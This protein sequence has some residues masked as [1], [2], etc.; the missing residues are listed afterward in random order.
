MH[1]CTMQYL[2]G[3]TR[4][5]VAWALRRWCKGEIGNLV[6]SLVP[7]LSQGDLRAM[8]RGEGSGGGGNAGGANGR[9]VRGR[10]ARDSSGDAPSPSRLKRISS[11]ACIMSFEKGDHVIAR[12]KNGKWYDATVCK[13]Q[14]H[15]L[16]LITWKDRDARDRVKRAQHIRHCP[17]TLKKRLLSSSS[18][19]A[20][21]ALGEGRQIDFEEQVICKLVTWCGEPTTW[22]GK[23]EVVD[24]FKTSPTW[25]SWVR[26]GHTEVQ[27]VKL[28]NRLKVKH[29]ERPIQHFPTAVRTFKTIVGKT[30]NQGRGGGG[31]RRASE[32]EKKEDKK[33]ICGKR[34]RELQGNTIPNTVADTDA[35][36]NAQKRQ[37]RGS[38]MRAAPLPSPAGG[39]MHHQGH[40][41]KGRNKRAS[42]LTTRGR[43]KREKEKEDSKKLEE[44]ED[45]GKRITRGGDEQMQ[46][47]STTTSKVR[48]PTLR[49]WKHGKWQVHF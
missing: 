11:A 3:N 30:L 35:L 23:K 15:G 2:V 17:S 39:K 1:V 49:I 14:R 27:L 25:H 43:K 33:G 21:E 26:A 22:N 12:Y 19:S 6:S 5:K 18:Q 32:G 9:G 46:T 44:E 47:T 8:T 29:L 45:E 41:V 20:A 48:L 42:R 40:H 28:I 7:F 34:R 38:H 16:F 10:E 37:T 36:P 4:S 31:A 24:R 13:K